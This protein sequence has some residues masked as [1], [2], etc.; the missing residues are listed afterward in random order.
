M[1]DHDNCTTPVAVTGGG[2]DAPTSQPPSTNNESSELIGALLQMELSIVA[3][4][5]LALL[6]QCWRQRKYIRYNV[7]KKLQLRHLRKRNL[8]KEARK[9]FGNLSVRACVLACPPCV[10]EVMQHQ[11]HVARFVG[12]GLRALN[13]LFMHV[14]RI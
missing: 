6:A 1:C 11:Q 9:F 4:L 13:G 14:P 7:V 5:V 2:S 3:L 8:T 10:R 12:R